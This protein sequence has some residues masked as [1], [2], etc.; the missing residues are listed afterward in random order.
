MQS[1]DV[2]SWKSQSLLWSSWSWRQGSEE[3]RGICT[4]S[5]SYLRPGLDITDVL[6]TLL[7]SPAKIFF[8]LKLLLS[9][10]ANSCGNALGF[11]D[12]VTVCQQSV[13]VIL[14]Q[15][16]LLTWVFLFLSLLLDRSK[17]C[18]VRCLSVAENSWLPFLVWS[19]SVLQ[20]NGEE[21]SP[22]ADEV[23]EA[24]LAVTS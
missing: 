21:P 1:E 13:K 3:D 6:L 10:L 24:V 22:A 19:F 17:F 14:A 18:S 5:C 7:C 9:E 2:P 12:V 20:L 23:L 11:V 15:K 4:Y 8:H 16:F